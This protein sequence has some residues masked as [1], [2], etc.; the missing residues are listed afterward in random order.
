MCVFFLIKLCTQI[1]KKAREVPDFCHVGVPGSCELPRVDA[2]NRSGALEDH[3][4]LLTTKISLQP[5][6]IVVLK[7]LFMQQFVATGVQQERVFF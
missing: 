6:V 7:K 3:Q 4:A 2:G 1:V 5:Q